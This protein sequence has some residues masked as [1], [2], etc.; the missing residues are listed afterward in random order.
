MNERLTLQDLIDLLAKKQ[1]ITKKDAE[2]FLRELIAVITENIEKNET[3]RIKDFGTFKLVL[4]SSRKS[5][6]VNTG[7]PIEIPPHYKLSF[8]PEKNLREAV[9]RPFAHFESVLIEEGADFSEVTQEF[10]I[11][12]PD[13]ENQNLTES[14]NII[15]IDDD[16]KDNELPPPIPSLVIDSDNEDTPPPIPSYETDNTEIVVESDQNIGILDVEQI[17]AISSSIIQEDTVVLKEDDSLVSNDNGENKL[18]SPKEEDDK[19]RKTIVSAETDVKKVVDKTLNDVPT[20]NNHYKFGDKDSPK[21]IK[22]RYDWNKYIYMGIV[23]IFVA[24]LAYFGFKFYRSNWHEA[25]IISY[26]QNNSQIKIYDEQ[27]TTNIVD[28]TS[29]SASIEEKVTQNQMVVDN[30]LK[31]IED[32][33]KTTSQ[34]EK[35]NSTVISKTQPQKGQLEKEKKAESTKKPIDAPKNIILRQ[36]NTLRSLGLEYYG[37]KSFWV[38]IYEENKNIITNPNNIP[39]GTELKIAPPEKYGID[40]NNKASLQKARE[41]E[42]VLFSKMQ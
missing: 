25:P 23:V 14:E 11:T 34:V 10:S 28:T 33:L 31:S 17:P 4:V 41:L 9:N 30:T 12:Q 35:E 38:Y 21:Y 42:S 15:T 37:N 13:L 5:V 26:D 32:K 39:L 20:T 22:N 8:A 40:A 27:D 1:E 24:V 36:G 18:S 19:I 6:D 16:E 3:V 7:E 29:N 2:T